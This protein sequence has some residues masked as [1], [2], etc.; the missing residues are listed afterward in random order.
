MKKLIRILFFIV[1]MISAGTSHQMLAQST[2]EIRVTFEAYLETVRNKDNP[3]TIEYLYPG[4]FNIIP[5]ETLLQVMNQLY[6]DSTVNVSYLDL[7]LTN[8]SDIIPHEEK[9]YA[10]VSYSNKLQMQ[11][12]TQPGEDD[13]EAM[14]MTLNAFNN[15]YGKENVAYEADTQT[16][17]IYSESDVYAIKD[18]AYDGWKF[19]EKKDNLQP[20]LQQLIPAAISDKL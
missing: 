8:V 11:F 9:A 16:F 7:S 5:K 4:L 14:E 13:T 18:P 15:A 17:T 3:A 10:L 19:I 1:T 2:E 20:I 6:S 12:I